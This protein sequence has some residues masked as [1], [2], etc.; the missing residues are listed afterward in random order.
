MTTNSRARDRR[1][2]D[3][4]KAPI[5]C[6]SKRLASEHPQS[7]DI[8]LSGIRVYSDNTLHTGEELE[9]QLDLPDKQRVQCRA[10]VVWVK[11]L[12][13]TDIAHYEVG[14]QFI[15]LS[16]DHLLMLAYQI[17]RITLL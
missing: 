12:A 6:R 7:L 1:R 11:P 3:R 14:L 15:D 8:S 10:T 13:A 9:I 17:K 5:D 2:H 16:A 4:I